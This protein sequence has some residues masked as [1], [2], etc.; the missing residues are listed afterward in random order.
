MSFHEWVQAMPFEFWLGFALSAISFLC[1]IYQLHR[2]KER[3]AA[4]VFLFGTIC[5]VGAIGWTFF[6]KPD[7][8]KVSHDARVSAAART[9][10]TE[11]EKTWINAWPNM[12]REPDGVYAENLNRADR[13]KALSL[14]VEGLVLTSEHTILHVAVKNWTI[15]TRANLEAAPGAYI[16]DDLGRNY[17]FQTELRFGQGPFLLDGEVRPGIT[18]RFELLFPPVQP[19][20]YIVLKHP[21]F[22]PIKVYQYKP[23]PATVSFCRPSSVVYFFYGMDVSCDGE[24]IADLANGKSAAVSLH[25]GKHSC[26]VKYKLFS[27]GQ[28]DLLEL[29]V[30]AGKEYYVQAEYEVGLL[31]SQLKLKPVLSEAQCMTSQ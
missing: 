12:T 10:V 5:I 17:N 27:T 9:W 31:S 19:T 26:Q 14:W 11:E 20:R 6:G 22:L 2:G 28:S 21:Q 18:E 16:I 4:K 8:E 7:L 30:L 13:L 24:H 23:A 25:P 1:V 29:E 15:E 3:R